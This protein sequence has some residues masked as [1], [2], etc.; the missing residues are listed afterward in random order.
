MTTPTSPS[1][2]QE[3]KQLLKEFAELASTPEGRHALLSQL[4]VRI[5]RTRLGG[6]LLDKVRLMYDYYRDPNEPS[7]PKWLMGGALLYLI[8]P[9]DLIPDWIPVIGMLDDAAVIAFVW[10]RVK[11]ILFNYAERREERRIVEG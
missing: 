9:D 7:G 11:D 8:I 4:E 1:L 10:S 6:P 5:R 3:L 2:A